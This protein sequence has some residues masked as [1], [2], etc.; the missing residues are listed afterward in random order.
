[1]VTTEINIYESYLDQSVRPCYLFDQRT[2]DGGRS[3]RTEARGQKSEVR[4]QKSGG[5][6]KE[7]E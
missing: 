6:G 2:E 1:M 3:Q 7:S 5:Q 4:G